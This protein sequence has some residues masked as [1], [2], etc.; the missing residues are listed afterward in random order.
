MIEVAKMRRTYGHK[1][2][3]FSFVELKV[4]KTSP[5]NDASKRMAD[6]TNLVFLDVNVIEKILDLNSQSMSRFL[7]ILF[8]SPLIHIRK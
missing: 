6:K 3:E 8:S 4:F 2:V 7:D 5:G 1:M